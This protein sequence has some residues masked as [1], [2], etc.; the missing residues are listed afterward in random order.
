MPD[1]YRRFVLRGVDFM[2]NLTN[3]A[4]LRESPAAEHHLA[5]A[6][7]RA[8]ETRRALVRC[9]NNGVTCVVDEFGHIQSDRRLP[10]HQEG[11]LVC[12]VPLP[13][14]RVLTFYV[15][16]GDWFVAACALISAV[17]GIWL[18]WRLRSRIA[19]TTKR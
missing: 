5:N 12:T 4:W 3:D 19:L 7:F 8:V 16:H 17:A 9:T 13:R 15:R 11:L 2:V 18:A 6:I 1:L 14:E 10:P